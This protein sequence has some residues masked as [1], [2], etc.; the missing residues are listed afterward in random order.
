MSNVFVVVF[1][2]L[3][4]NCAHALTTVKVSF[5]EALAPTDT[6]SSDRFQKE[7]EAAIDIGLMTTKDKLKKCGYKIDIEKQFYSASDSIQAL[8]F[9]EKSQKNGSWLI[10]GPRR[11]N[12][13]LL[14]VKGASETASVS[15][16]ASSK[17]VFDLNTLH[18]TL[19]KANSV[20]AEALAVAVKNELGTQKNYI[21]ITSE[22]CISCL[23]FRDQFNIYAKN[24][25]LLSTKDFL[26]TGEQPDIKSIIN[27]IKNNDIQIVLVP[28]Y[29]KLSAYLIG[30][31]K[32]LKPNIIFLGGDGW[33][34]QKFGFIHKSPHLGNAIGFT[35][36]GFPNF[37]KGLEVL[38]LP[39]SVQKKL[40]SSVIKISS[41][42]SL[43]IISSIQ[44]FADMLCDQK[45][46]DI[47]SFKKVFVES[48]KKYFKNKWGVSLYKLNQGEVAFWKN[49]ND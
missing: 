27:Y 20:M 30:Q 21:S 28:N 7:Y 42:S 2:I 43:A 34:D 24:N 35:V 6:T 29:S 10:I 40:K 17:E 26:I 9:S 16:M 49:V 18:L 11:S 23:D 12:H 13:Y 32:E 41:G 45:P 22:D 19:G 47:N 46:V 1:T 39:K 48:G 14:S 25:S 3:F 38:N 15:L 33:G 44:S 31:I 37:E 8:E 4:L 5:L 36:K